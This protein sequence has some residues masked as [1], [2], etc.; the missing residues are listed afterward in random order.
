MSDEEFELLWQQM[1][2]MTPAERAAFHE[3]L[4]EQRAQSEAMA[5]FL[6]DNLFTDAPDADEVEEEP[7]PSCS[8]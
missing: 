5:D 7:S 8:N 3:Q 1:Q 4:D 2:R 6:L